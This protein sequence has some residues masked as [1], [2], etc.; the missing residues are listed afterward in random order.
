[1]SELEKRVRRASFRRPLNNIQVIQRLVVPLFSFFNS[2]FLPCSCLFFT[3][4]HPSIIPSFLFSFSSF[5]LSCLQIFL[6]SYF[7]HFLTF[8]PVISFESHPLVYF[9]SSFSNF[10]F[11]IVCSFLILLYPP[12]PYSLTHLLK[13]ALN[14][15]EIFQIKYLHP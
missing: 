8:Y 13:Y 2:V 10:L 15:Q 6:L 11:I 1:M 12:F 14:H 5:L 3:F 7:F 9:S 4:N